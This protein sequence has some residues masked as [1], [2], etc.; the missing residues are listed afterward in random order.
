MNSLE[1][2][3]HDLHHLANPTKAAIL[4]C[5]FKN[6]PGEYGYN[7]RFLGVM[8]SKLHYLAKT[9]YESLQLGDLRSLLRSELHEERSLALIILVLKYKKANLIDQKRIFE[10]YFAFV[11]RIN[12]WDLVDSSA[13]HIVGAYLFDKEKFFLYKLVQS[14]NL[15]QRRISIVS[16]LYFIRNGFYQETLKL[17]RRLLRDN[18]DL[19]HKATGWILREV[20]KRDFIILNDF[21]FKY[22]RIMP[23][24]M[25]RYAI[26]N[27]SEKLRQDYLHDRIN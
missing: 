8:R 1:N 21:L 15:W 25:L 19:I 13:P 10:F 9:H 6:K 14:E 5:F 3:Y 20:G 26:E 2:L 4:Q 7:D 27:F 18:E 16:T 11:S 17:A 22:Y 12:S 24:T 23:R